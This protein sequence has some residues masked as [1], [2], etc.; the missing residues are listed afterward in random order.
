VTTILEKHNIFVSKVSSKKA[1]CHSREDEQLPPLAGNPATLARF[2]VWRGNLGT[3]K[4]S[5]LLSYLTAVNHFNKD[6]G[7][8]PVALGDV[9][10]RVSMGLVS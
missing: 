1:K 9:V 6:H 2:V 7:H 8:E 5:S 4:A 3:I 10:A